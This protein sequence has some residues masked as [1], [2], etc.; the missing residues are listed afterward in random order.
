MTDAIRVLLDLQNLSYWRSE[1]GC[2]CAC[3]RII[4]CGE[5]YCELCQFDPE[6]LAQKLCEGY[7]AAE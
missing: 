4:D 7:S 5:V 3:G 6:I 1:M 2:K